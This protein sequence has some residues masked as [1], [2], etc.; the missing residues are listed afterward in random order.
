MRG[1]NKER[2]HREGHNKLIQDYF[3]PNSTYNDRDFE[4]R[5]R[6][7]REVFMKIAAELESA[8]PY[9]V[10]KPVRKVS[11]Y[12]FAFISFL[13]PSFPFPFPFPFFFI[14]FLELTKKLSTGLY[15]QIRT[16]KLPKDY[17]CASTTSV[18]MCCGC[19]R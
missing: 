12:F 9:F 8:C 19:H 3:S 4:R 18:W 15:R 11:F 10:Q 6:M 14:S 2:N 13:F 16:F 5:F 7:R 17:L 1:P